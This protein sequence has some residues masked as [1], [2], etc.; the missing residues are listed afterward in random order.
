M[1][2][3]CKFF[4][5]GLVYNISRT[6]FSMSPC[7]Y[8]KQ[9]SRAQVDRS[10]VE[11]YQKFRTE[12]ANSNIEKNCAICQH[13][14]LSGQKSYRQAANNIVKKDTDKLVMLTVAVN[15]TCNL[16]CPTCDSNSS[17][18]WYQENLRNNVPQSE[19]VIQLHQEDR[20]QVITE[21][22]LK[23]FKE[24]DLS[25][26]EYIKFGGGEPLMNDTHIKILELI[27]FKEN[28]I[29]QYTSNFS[30]MPSDS[31]FSLWE[32]FKLI[33][34]MASLDGIESQ[35]EFLRWPYK[36]KKFL[37]FKNTAFA[38]V[39]NNVMFGIEH[40]VNPLNAFYFDR[41]EQWFNDEFSTNRLG[42]HSDLNVHYADGIL[43]LSN[44]PESLKKL[45]IEKYGENHL[46][47]T[48]LRLQTESLYSIN[49]T[50]KYLDDINI[51]RNVSWRQIFPDVEKYF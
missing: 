32:K 38:S 50:V 46:I 13:Q 39:P 35:H 26:I 10:V 43:G 12:W 4:N 33:K 42:D 7:C 37:K 40:T 41:F 15:K 51:W 36:W 44:T 6:N 5:N 24:T 18:F 1:T 20:E 11:Q 45:I 48:F 27:P 9:E 34:W 28:V 49:K 19:L 30:I 22:F 3:Y 47:S 16:A 17:S 2:D 21:K 31:V 25:D 8:F 23:F 14:E 29:V